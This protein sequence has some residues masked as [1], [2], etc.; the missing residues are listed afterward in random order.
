MSGRS[1]GVG[2]LGLQVRDHLGIVLVAQPLVGVDEHVAVMLAAVVAALGDRWL[3]DSVMRRS[4][5]RTADRKCVRM[6][7]CSASRVRRS[8]VGGQRRRR[9]V[10]VPVP[11]GVRPGQPVADELLVEAV[12]NHTLLVASSAR[13]Y[14]GRVRGEH[15]IGQHH[16]AVLDRPRTR[17]WCRR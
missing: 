11:A 1:L 5:R 2:V 16:V 12:L 7:R 13:Q 15:L 3:A 6:P 4:N 8:D 9:G 10:A 14:R 17:T